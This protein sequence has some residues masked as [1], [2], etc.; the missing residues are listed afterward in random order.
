MAKAKKVRFGSGSEFVHCQ[1]RSMSL[2]KA[3]VR[4]QSV[5]CQKRSIVVLCLR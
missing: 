2:S 1:E 4:P 3:E 5:L